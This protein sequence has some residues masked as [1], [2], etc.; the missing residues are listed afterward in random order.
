[1]ELDLSKMK[2]LMPKEIVKDLDEITKEFE[3]L[4]VES[5][6]IKYKGL[7]FKLF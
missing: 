5:V 1:M 7:W 4:E 6:K 3:K 2:K